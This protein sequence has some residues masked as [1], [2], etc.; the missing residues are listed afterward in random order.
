MSYP[1]EGTMAPDFTLDT[2]A[3]TPLTLSSLRGRPVVLFFYPKDDTP[4]CT[5]ESCEF[6]DLTPRFQGVKAEVLGI[7]PDDVKS[8]VKFRK[9]FD[10]PYPLLADVGHP[11]AELGVRHLGPYFTGVGT[12]TLRGH[13]TGTSV[14]CVEEFD[15]PAAR[16]LNPAG[17]L[18]LPVLQRGFGVSLKRFAAVCERA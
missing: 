1:A 5:I 11:V 16:V 14:T 3:G 12:F 15:L 2:D 13:E 10:L 6:R 7:S 17:R 4:G 9:K 8:H 18:L